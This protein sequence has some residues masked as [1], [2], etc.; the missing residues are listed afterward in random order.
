[1]Q[2]RHFLLPLLLLF[3]IAGC[4]TYGQ[5]TNYPDRRYPDNRRYPDTRRSDRDRQRVDRDVRDYVRILDRN[6]RLNQQQEQRIDRL[7]SDRTYRLLDRSRG[8]SQNDLYP[9]PRRFDRRQNQRVEAWWNEI[10]RD[11]ERLLDRRQRDEYR[12]LTRRYDR[13][14]Q[15]YDDRYDKE[16]RKY[17]KKRQ[18]EY[19]KEQKKRY[20]KRKKHDDDD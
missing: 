8:Y 14:D 1:M 17:E 6:L 16:Y 4:A 18:K 3:L 10:D 9:F 12:Y 20:K 13:R 5:G 11:V 19:E 15:R 7:I 2:R